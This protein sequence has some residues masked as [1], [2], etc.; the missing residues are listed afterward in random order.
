M[1]EETHFRHFACSGMF[2]LG[3]I[4]MDVLGQPMF[5]FLTRTFHSGGEKN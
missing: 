4:S 1:A 5:L 2:L 3:M